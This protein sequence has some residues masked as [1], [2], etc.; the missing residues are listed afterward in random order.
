M[1]RYALPPVKS[2]PSGQRGSEVY[3]WMAEPHIH[4]IAVALDRLSGLV[5]FQ[6]KRKVTVPLLKS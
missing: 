6:H 1:E 4:S 2:A 5:A 3:A